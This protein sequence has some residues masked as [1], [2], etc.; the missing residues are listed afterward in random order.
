MKKI[1]M[2]VTAA[3]LVFS[4]A[5]CSGQGGS[6]SSNSGSSTSQSAADQSASKFSDSGS[7]DSGLNTENAASREKTAQNSTKPT[8]KR[9]VIYNAHMTIT[10]NQFKAAQDDIQSIVSDMGGYI[11]QSSIHKTE[12]DKQRG[13]MRVRIPQP[14]FQL[15]LDK[16]E[17]IAGT[18]K[19]R[20]ISGRDVTKQYVDLQSRLKAKMAVKQ[21]LN[22]FLK[23]AKDSDA[24]LDISNQLANVQEEI[25]HIKGEMKYLEN[26]SALATVSIVLLETDTGL[27]QQDDLDT[28]GKVK[29]AFVDSLN[30]LVSVVSGLIVFFIGYSPI[31]I[32]LFVIA[33]IAYVVYRQR[34]RKGN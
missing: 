18:V 7:S 13:E 20:N 10:V 32:I 14:K 23:Q 19:E 6:E 30:F 26:H 12:I 29:N 15:F 28:W 1:M 27:K 4:L 5:A 17:G 31:L 24:L 22:K 11:V 8:P 33:A 21:R 9:M 16:V 2:L 3:L 25:E 34:K